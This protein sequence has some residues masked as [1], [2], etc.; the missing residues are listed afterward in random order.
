M[1]D[2]EIK[3]LYGSALVSPSEDVVA[4]SY[5]TWTLTYTAG[6]KGVARGGTIRIYTDADSDRATPQMDD[7]TG[8]GL[9]DG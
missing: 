7:P 1:S 8:A 5:G 4:G 9:F 2:V 3:E 6:E